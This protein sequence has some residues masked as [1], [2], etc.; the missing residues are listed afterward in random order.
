MEAIKLCE[1]LVTIRGEDLSQLLGRWEG[2]Q[3]SYGEVGHKMTLLSGESERFQGFLKAAVE[4][5]EL[6]VRILD[7]EE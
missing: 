4:E 1:N 7:S 3:A 6:F 5:P 2:F